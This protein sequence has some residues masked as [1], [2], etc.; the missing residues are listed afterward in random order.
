MWFRMSETKKIYINK[1]SGIKIDISRKAFVL[2]LNIRSSS[3]SKSLTRKV[4]TE[5]I[6]PQFKVSLCT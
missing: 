4:A 3:V 2:F 5:R 1:L 6:E